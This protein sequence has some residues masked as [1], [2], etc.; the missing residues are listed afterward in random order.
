M[1][2]QYFEGLN[3]DG[4]PGLYVF[5]EGLNGPICD[6]CNVDI[7]IR[8]VPLIYG[9]YAVC[10]DCLAREYP[11]WRKRVPADVIAEWERQNSK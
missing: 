2:K 5:T 4:D 1:E 6:I 9:N 10:L 8:P 7:A 3:L 11:D